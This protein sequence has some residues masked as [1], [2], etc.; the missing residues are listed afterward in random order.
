MLGGGRRRQMVVEPCCLKD[1]RTLKDS[2]SFGTRLP[3]RVQKCVLATQSVLQSP[4][5]STT[6]M[7]RNNIVKKAHPM[8]QTPRMRLQKCWWRLNEMK[9]EPRRLRW[10]KRLVEETE[11]HVVVRL[12]LG[13]LLLLLGG[14]LGGT[15]GGGSSATGSGGGTARGDGSELGRALS[16]ELNVSA[17]S[18]N[19]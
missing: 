2:I 4:S 13:L 1:G 12:L 18:N 6:P 9:R 3:V 19:W 10:S 7:Q 14:G 15:T 8:H 11:A 16:D 5:R 17:S